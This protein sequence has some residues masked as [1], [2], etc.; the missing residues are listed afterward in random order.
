MQEHVRK[1]KKMLEKARILE[2]ARKCLNYN[3]K[4]MQENVSLVF[5]A[6]PII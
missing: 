1:F 3:V 2:N 6:C 5:F 4:N